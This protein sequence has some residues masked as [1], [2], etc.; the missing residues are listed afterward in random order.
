MGSLNVSHVRLVSLFGIIKKL[1][2]KGDCFRHNKFEILPLGE[3]CCDIFV[4]NVEKVGW[5]VVVVTDHTRE[6]LY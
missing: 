1:I 4:A 2:Q 3:I 6:R 5:R